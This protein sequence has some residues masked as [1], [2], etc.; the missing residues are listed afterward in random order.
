MLRKDN[1]LFRLF[2]GCKVLAIFTAN[3]S[4]QKDSDETNVGC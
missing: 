2:V 1:A 3:Q 4:N